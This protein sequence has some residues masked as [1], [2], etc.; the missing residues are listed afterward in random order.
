MPRLRR[1]RWYPTGFANA[2]RSTRQPQAAGGGKSSE[3]RARL[4]GLAARQIVH[5]ILPVHGS[6]GCASLSPEVHAPAFEERSRPGTPLPAWC[7]GKHYSLKPGG[8]CRDVPARVSAGLWPGDIFSQIF[9][10]RYFQADIFGIARRRIPTP[11]G[12]G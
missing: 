12:I 11:A 10:A 9:S 4:Q 1:R 5:G 3:G 7:W 8:Q 6:L 2:P